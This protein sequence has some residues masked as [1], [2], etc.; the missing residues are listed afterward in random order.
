MKEHNAYIRI[1]GET[2]HPN[3]KDGKKGVTKHEQLALYRKDGTI[4]REVFPSY[5][6]FIPWYHLKTNII[7]HIRSM[8]SYMKGGLTKTYA[9]CVIDDNDNIIECKKNVFEE[10]LPLKVI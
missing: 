7:R 1:I 4:V 6:R 2:Y 8:G 5:C 3:I 9:V 10:N